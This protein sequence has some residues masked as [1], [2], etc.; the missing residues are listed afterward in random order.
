MSDL[1]HNTLLLVA[2]RSKIY[3]PMVVRETEI[4]DII[5]GKQWSRSRENH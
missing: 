1:S 2:P 4:D 5:A 3:T